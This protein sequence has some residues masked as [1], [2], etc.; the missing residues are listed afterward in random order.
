M[1]SRL[2]LEAAIVFE[3]QEKCL[4]YENGEGVL[5]E[6]KEMLQYATLLFLE[7]HLAVAS[8]HNL[9]LEI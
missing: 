9:T 8:F 1:I 2:P 5:I 4:K 3:E 7:C 6:I